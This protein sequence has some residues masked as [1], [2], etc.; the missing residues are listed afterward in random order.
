MRSSFW[1]AAFIAAI[2]VA[3]LAAPLAQ[4]QNPTGD[5]G[6]TVTDTDGGGE[7]GGGEGGNAT[8]HPAM[9]AERRAPGRRRP[10]RRTAHPIR[11]TRGLSSSAR[12]G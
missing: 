8:N 2:A 10:R 6:G 12:K 9:V 1:R 7:Q 3:F 4:A 5:I 11:R